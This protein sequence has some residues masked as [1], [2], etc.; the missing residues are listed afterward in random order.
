MY[1]E[2]DARRDVRIIW[3]SDAGIA[4]MVS[5]QDRYVVT[6]A[7]TPRFAAREYL[8]RYGHL[9]GV[10][11]HHL[12][13]LLRPVEDRPVD[14]S[15]AFRLEAEKHHFDLATVVFHQTYLGLPVWE[16]GL[17]VT[18]KHETR[19]V[20]GARSTSHPKF[21]IGRTSAK[22]LEKLQKLDVATLAQHL[23]LARHVDDSTPL[24]INDERLMVHQHD[25]ARL[26]HATARPRGRDPAFGAGAPSLPL[27]PVHASIRDGAHYVVRAVNFSFDFPPIRPLHWVALIEAQT[28]SVLLL[29]PF[30]DDVIGLVFRADPATLGG[31]RAQAGNSALN[32]WR[33]PVTLDGLAA[34]RKGLQELR[35]KH[36][37]IADVIAPSVTPPAMRAG[38]KFAFNARS[39]D[40]AA[41]SAYYN[42]SR[43]FQ[44]V[45]R[46]GFSVADYFPKTKFPMRVDHRGHYGKTKPLGIEINAHCAA[47]ER[48]T[49]IAYTTFSLADTRNHK[50]PI[51]I[52]CDWRIV[53]HELLGHGVLYNHIGSPRFKFSHSA[54][55]SF[56]AIINDPDTKACDRFATFPWLSGIPKD[57]QRRHDRTPAGGFG[58][59]GDIAM[60]PLD[61]DKDW[62]GYQ[63]EQ[64][65]SSTMFRF[66]QAIGG[67]SRKPADRRFAADMTCH[68]ML[69]AIQ[70]FTAATSPSNAAHFASALMKAEIAAWPAAGITGGAYH[71]VIRWAFEKQGLYQHGDAKRPN[72]N[73]GSPP[74]VDVYIEDGRHGEYQYQPDYWNCQAIW[75]RHRSDR[76]TDHEAPIPGV[77]NYAYVK[78]KNRGYQTAKRVAV[79]GFFSARSGECAY[80]RDWRPMKT[81]KLAARDVPPNSSAEIIV[82]PFAWTPL[83][84]KGN[85]MIM[86][87]SALG[88]SSNIDNLHSRI[89]APNARLVPH[90]NNI[91]QRDV[92]APKRTPKQTRRP[93]RQRRGRR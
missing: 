86:V 28:G 44:L 21:K 36:V 47:D 3:S 76:G 31:P 54:G 30:V 60:H 43:V 22:H 75:N 57:A 68:I 52:A 11:R 65:L 32:R 48:G 92:A 89:P 34:P 90:D 23:G 59:G 83:R 40:F 29:R 87:V 7:S 19:R 24:R 17:S 64:I 70:S 80:P 63:N 10:Q 78:I 45:E 81:A 14:A 25:A 5:H 41:V 12:K 35:G 4:R 74:P 33:S 69:A 38:R 62:G 16:A 85:R 8:G 20:I 46:L 6:R 50:Q 42:C 56:A 66:Y 71:K 18:M 13:D 39:N 55:D 91:S 67:D 53:L 37:H 49:G 88:D 1:E 72:N 93:P 27:P 82:G 2:L 58:W 61:P 15:V 51:G 84:G 79:R 73:E 26:R 9:F 77:I